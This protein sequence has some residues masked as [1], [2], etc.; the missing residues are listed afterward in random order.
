[1]SDSDQYDSDE[2]DSDDDNILI[3]VYDHNEPCKTRFSIAFCELYNEKR[4]GDNSNS[5]SYVTLLRAKYYPKYNF[6]NLYICA[7]AYNKMYKLNCKLLTPHSY[8]RNYKNIINNSNINYIKPEIA[9]CITLE[10][11][12]NVS[13]IKTIWLRLIQR[14]WKRIYRERQEFIRKICRYSA[15]KEREYTGRWPANLLSS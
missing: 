14:K 9:E 6:D 8:I 1:M 11:G 5:Y 12:V 3:P 4:H 13:I 7:D 10:S 2:D 15:L